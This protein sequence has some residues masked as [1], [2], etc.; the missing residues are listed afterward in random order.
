MKR[1]IGAAQQVHQ[2]GQAL[3]ILAVDLD[4]LQPVGRLAVWR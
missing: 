3:D 4:Q 1:K 2:A